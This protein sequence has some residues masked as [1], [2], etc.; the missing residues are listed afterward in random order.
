MPLFTKPQFN[1]VW[2][3]AGT[4]LTPDNSKISL[5]WVV[6]IP[7]HEYE[8]WIQNRQDAMLAHLNQLGIP[9]WDSTV[10]YQAGKSYVQG[11]T[12]G[13]VY[14]ALTTHININ[15]EI[16]I[17]NN[18]V[19]AFEA[20]GNALLK[21]QNLADVPDKALARTNLGIAT[22]EFYDGRYLL[23]GSN[24]SDVPNKATARTNLGLGNSATL[25][26]GN[27]AGTVAAGDDT[28][29]VNS[30]QNSRS[31]LA[32]NGLTGGGNLLTDRSIVLGTPGH[33]TATSTNTV[34]ATSHTHAVDIA[35]FFQ[36]NLTASKGHY[37]LPG[38]LIINW[39]RHNYSGSLVGDS[40]TFDKPFTSAVFFSGCEGDLTQTT[41]VEVGQ[42]GSL[43]LTGMSVSN[44]Y[45]TAGATGPV[46]GQV[47]WFAVG[48]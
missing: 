36:R 22:T 48:V 47:I 5:G 29:I 14:R 16:D 46:P 21:S 4:K 25:N 19:V 42:T 39:G 20:S 27:S 37:V 7:P 8:N 17:S 34:T 10:E 24:F 40:V 9:L 28:R 31:I 44:S 32:G 45:V 30:V 13:V 26:V 43:S 35:S 23:K 3:S 1:S 18:W 2:A 41:F 38:G 15:P 12:S 11:T 6:E 33:L